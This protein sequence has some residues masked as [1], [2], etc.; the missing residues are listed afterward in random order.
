MTDETRDKQDKQ[1]TGQGA[2]RSGSAASGDGTAQPR[3]ET[4]ADRAKLAENVDAVMDEVNKAVRVAIIKGADAAESISDNIRETI[5]TVR[6]NRDNVVMVRIDD[7]SLE[8]VDELVEAG[9][10]GSRSEASAFLIAEGIKARQPLFDRIADK[11]AE[12]RSAKEDLRRMV[13]DEDSAQQS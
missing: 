1:D 10:L 8:R 12:I 6:P 4:Q 11:I 7:S 13:Q 5:R 9:I 3:A 2:S